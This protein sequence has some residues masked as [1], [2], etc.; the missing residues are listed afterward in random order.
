MIYTLDDIE[1]ISKQPYEYTLDHSVLKLLREIDI[2]INDSKFRLRPEFKYKSKIIVNR[3]KI[4]GLI[5]TLRLNMNKLSDKN[6]T[7][8]L[9]KIRLN[10]SELEEEFE[11]SDVERC[12]L[13]IFEIA[14]TNLFYSNLY[15]RLYQDLYKQFK[16]LHKP[17]NTTLKTFIQSYKEIEAISS[18]ENY[19]LFCKIIKNNDRRLAIL[20]FL[21]QLIKYGIVEVK[22]VYD[23][24]YYIISSTKDEKTT[25]DEIQQLSEHLH[26]I[27]KEI[28]TL[29]QDHII[30]NAVTVH[31]D[32]YRQMK[33][34][35]NITYKTIFKYMDINDFIKT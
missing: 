29:L 10:L 9:E 34:N 5:D 2:I 13:I 14:S 28:K 7:T 27:I 16:W 31:V 33:P 26:I 15:A 32:T 24:I 11:D 6:Y 19:D 23:I 30:W 4:N 3:D 21:T 35:G 17:L 22:F 1:Q 20:N 12:A 8:Q 18:I 25:K